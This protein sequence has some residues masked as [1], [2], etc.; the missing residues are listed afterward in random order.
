MARERTGTLPLCGRGAE[1]RR[2]EMRPRIYPAHLET[3]SAIAGILNGPLAAEF[4]S[5]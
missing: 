5:L 3:T 4:R 1:R 2:D